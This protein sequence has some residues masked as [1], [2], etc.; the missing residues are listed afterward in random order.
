LKREHSALVEEL[1][2]HE[3]LIAELGKLNQGPQIVVYDR[4][5]DERS[6]AIANAVLSDWHVDE[7]VDR[8]AMHGRNE[9]NPDIAKQRAHRCFQNLLRLTDIFAKDSRITTISL[10]MLG[11]FFSGW[12][13]EELLSSTAMAPGDAA[14]F[15]QSLLVSGIQFLLDNG[16]YRVEAHCVP[17]NHGR[18]TERVHFN[19]PTGTS[20]ETYM[21]AHVADW[22]RDE[23]RVSINVARTGVVYHRM[24]ESFT[25][26]LIHGYEVRYA[27][28]VGGI[29]SPL[30]KWLYRAD[31]FVKADMTVMGHFHTLNFDRKFLVNPSLIGF[32]RYAEA[33]GF[34][35]EPSAQMFWLVHARNGGEWSGLNPIWVDDANGGAQEV[36]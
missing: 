6:D 9:Y 26:R 10:K 3:A 7:L 19:D 31:T 23:P 18:M 21:Y 32:N 15:A 29:S 8:N 13:H 16:P 1:R 17:G 11:D 25:E 34:E 36:A 33:N 27:G 30:K 20:L 2:R 4:A 14:N 35:F 24:F 12:I 5:K 22:F 28:G